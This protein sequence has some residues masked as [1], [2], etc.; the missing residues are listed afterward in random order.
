MGFFLF[1]TLASVSGKQEGETIAFLCCLIPSG[2]PNPAESRK[3][4]PL[5][6]PPEAWRKPRLPT[7]AAEGQFRRS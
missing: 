5:M 7:L 3:L 2:L 4:G 6:Q 1:L